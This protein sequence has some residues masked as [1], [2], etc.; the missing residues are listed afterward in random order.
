MKS[1]TIR[2]CRS[3]TSKVLQE[4]KEVI[5]NPGEELDIVIL[6]TAKCNQCKLKQ[7]RTIS[8]PKLPFTGN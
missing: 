4:D 1:I 7:I 8:G 3:C 6:T 2:E 5:L